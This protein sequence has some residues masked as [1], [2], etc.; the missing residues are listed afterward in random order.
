M[1]PD[2]ATSSGPGDRLVALLL[3]LVL[4]AI[5]HANG[6]FMVN[7]DALPNL[8]LPVSLLHEGNLSFTPDEVPFLF[9]W[10]IDTPA[11][12]KS[13]AI[14]RW[15]PG[16]ADLQQQNLLRVHSHK[17]YLVPSTRPGLYINMFAPGAGISAVPFLAI[18]ERFVGDLRDQPALL[19]RAGK[20]VGALGTA[21]AA[22]CVYLIARRF[23]PRNLSVA[24]AVIYGLGTSA[25]TLSSQSLL[26]HGTSEFLI[27]LGT[28]YLLPSLTLA[29]RASTATEPEDPDSGGAWRTIASGLAFGAAVACRP[30]AAIVGL[31]MLGYLVWCRRDQ[32]VPFLL[33]MLPIALL[34]AFYNT[35]YLGSPFKFGQTIWAQTFWEQTQDFPGVWSTPLAT[36]IA[37]ILISPS[38]GLFVYSPVMLFALWGAYRVWRPPGD[39]FLRAVSLAALAVLLVHA[40][41]FSWF[42]GHDFAYRLIV[43][44]MPHVALLLIPAWQ[45]LTAPVWRG[46]F[47][48]TA[49]AS[50]AVQFLGA[51]AFTLDGW[52]AR[53]GYAVRVGDEQILLTPDL[54]AAQASAAARGG[55]IAAVSMN[56]D[57]IPYRSRL[58]SLSD[59]QLEFFLSHFAAERRN[60][61]A[62]IAAYPDMLGAPPN[63]L[64]HYNLALAYQDLG[65]AAQAEEQFQAALA[66]KENFAPAHLNYGI[67]LATR[68]DLSAAHHHFQ[69]AWQLDPTVTSGTNLGHVS[70]QLGDFAQAVTVFRDTLQLEP[71]NLQLQLNLAT[72][73][74]ELGQYFEARDLLRQ[75]VQQA[76]E[77]PAVHLALAWILAAAP[78]DAVRDGTAA[79][80]AARRACELTNY[81]EPQTIDAL[82][83]A[84]AESGRYLE[85]LE[86]VER[87]LA[88]AERLKRTELIPELQAR[89]DLYQ[90]QQPYRTTPQTA[91]ESSP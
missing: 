64:T 51:F 56:I 80:T 68:G 67:A 21:A 6:D 16:F 78:D 39:R 12:P 27:A 52:N 72:A 35:Y 19:C 34:L 54:H 45:S 2:T 1:S 58:W 49:A 76:P 3:V 20:F 69:R 77:Q 8:Y 46:L 10:E 88:L 22:A 36:G 38:R 57:E 63:H 33:G 79:I 13:I 87:A 5:Y 4:L 7:N 85:A 55:T 89:R 37:G 59:N 83:A 41:W 66:L 17:Y 47:A 18:L 42:G 74:G 24:V 40:K 9:D 44:T 84:L 60:K 11:G 70:R 43:D 81:S 90:K 15:H 71:A 65:Q 31:V 30:T 50:I 75:T 32:V 73:L 62:A 25:W 48:L 91:T 86:T 26:Q 82:A 29:R 28:L 61:R 23:A 53:A 14:N